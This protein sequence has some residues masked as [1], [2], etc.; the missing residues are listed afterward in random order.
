MIATSSCC[1][2]LSTV[3]ITRNT[4]LPIRISCPSAAA[5]LP[6]NSSFTG[7]GPSTTTLAF[8]RSSC[9][10]KPRPSVSSR[11]VTVR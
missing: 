7:F 3:P 9:A 1:P 5:A 11:S 2:V 10:S 8:V 4:A 6:A